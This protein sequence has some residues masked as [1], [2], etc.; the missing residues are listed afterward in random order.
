MKW[1][2]VFLFVVPTPQGTTKVLEGKHFDGFGE[3]SY[4]T[5]VECEE[6]SK[7]YYRNHF[8]KMPRGVLNIYTRCELKAFAAPKF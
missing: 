7:F 4:E 8:P 3:R 1:F 2:L 5:Q 6:R